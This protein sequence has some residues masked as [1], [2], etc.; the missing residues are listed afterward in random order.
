MNPDG[1]LSRSLDWLTSEYPPSRPHRFVNVSFRVDQEE[2]Y[3]GSDQPQPYWLLNLGIGAV[4]PQP[5]AECMG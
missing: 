1:W 3:R 2:Q 4:G 5:W